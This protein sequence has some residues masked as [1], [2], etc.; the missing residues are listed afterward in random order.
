[1]P[2]RIGPEGESR[3]FDRSGIRGIPESAAERP[4]PIP[5][6]SR[7]PP[8]PLPQNQPHSPSSP[9]LGG[10]NPTDNPAYQGTRGPRQPQRS[11]TVFRAAG[12]RVGLAVDRAKDPEMWRDVVRAWPSPS[13]SASFGGASFRAG[14]PG[15]ASDPTSTTG[16]GQWHDTEGH[17][18]IHG[19]GPYQQSQASHS[20]HSVGQPH[21]FTGPGSKGAKDRV[22]RRGAWGIGSHGSGEEI[23]APQDAMLEAALEGSADR[24]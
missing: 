1:M 23:V 16:R 8:W 4:G 11:P 13:R 22:L 5:A 6:R 15:T 7:R 17:P 3:A 18:L 14:V 20:P 19:P 9:A 2:C 21:Y 12:A 10:P 24:R